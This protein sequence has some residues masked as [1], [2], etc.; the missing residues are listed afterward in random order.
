MFI[1]PGGASRYNGCRRKRI[2]C[3]YHFLYTVFLSVLK[4]QVFR[5]MEREITYVVGSGL[6]SS[7]LGADALP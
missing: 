2:T 4:L 6:I 1:D 7:L 5:W 3:T